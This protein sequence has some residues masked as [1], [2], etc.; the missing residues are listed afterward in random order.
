MRNL[1]T[2][3]AL[4]II[5]AT[6]QAKEIDAYEFV[7]SEMKASNCGTVEQISILN[8]DE[9]AF[10]VTATKQFGS[11]EVDCTTCGKQHLALLK[12]V[13]ENSCG[14]RTY[15]ADVETSNFSPYNG[16]LSNVSKYTL[17]L[18]VRKDHT[19]RGTK[20]DVQLNITGSSVFVMQIPEANVRPIKTQVQ[21]FKQNVNL[22]LKD[23]TKINFSSQPTQA[24]TPE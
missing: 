9:Q 22:V 17:T 3:F 5:S 12:L 11:C 18:P 16:A 19:C 20:N 7:S 1:I 2:I 10:L 4:L 24:G 13:S 23:I 8:S 21:V 6:V 14:T 15:V